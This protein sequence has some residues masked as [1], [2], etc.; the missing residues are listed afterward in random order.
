MERCPLAELVAANGNLGVGSAS[1]S[2]SWLCRLDSETVV[3]EADES[4]AGVKDRRDEKDVDKGVDGAT[5]S[6]SVVF[7]AEVLSLLL[8]LLL[9]LLLLLLLWFGP[10]AGETFRDKCLAFRIRFMS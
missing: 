8:L 2:N 6:G 3:S 9:F 5:I 7:F 10:G 4:G 1:S